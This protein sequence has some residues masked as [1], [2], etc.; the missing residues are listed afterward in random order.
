[1]SGYPA[2]Q[3]DDL[4]NRLSANEEELERFRKDPIPAL[5]ALVGRER[6]PHSDMFIYRLVVIALGIVI[7]CVVGVEIFVHV[8]SV[9]AGRDTSKY[10]LPEFLIAACST[11]IG[12]LAGLLAPIGP[13]RANS[14][15]I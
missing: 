4:I 9:I 14:K 7:L 6:H 12:A 2:R 11:S 8:D 15:E 10:P 5:V 13:N 3:I 1:M